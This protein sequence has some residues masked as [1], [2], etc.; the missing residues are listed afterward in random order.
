MLAKTCFESFRKF[1]KNVLSSVPF[2]QFDLSNLPTY[3]RTEA[4]STAKISRECC[5][6]F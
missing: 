6:N 3:N 4:G 1:Q 2:K 5:E